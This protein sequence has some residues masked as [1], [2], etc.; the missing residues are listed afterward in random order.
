M[1][2]TL[3]YI[4]DIKIIIYFYKKNNENIE[5]FKKALRHMA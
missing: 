1:M 4:V 3:V 5:E 2:I